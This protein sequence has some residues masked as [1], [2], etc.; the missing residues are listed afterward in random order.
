M[1]HRIV[2]DG[3]NVSLKDWG[4]WTSVEKD[5]DEYYLALGM[6]NKK[7]QIIITFDS[8]EYEDFRRLL[9]FTKQQL[10]DKLKAMNKLEEAK[11]KEFDE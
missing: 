11:E 6:G 4:L 2:E 10:E 3:K 5:E 1:I 7:E 9:M 8:E